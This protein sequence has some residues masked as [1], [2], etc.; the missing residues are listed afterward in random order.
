M[1][2]AHLPDLPF[3]TDAENTE[4][5]RIQETRLT[6]AE[7]DLLV[8]EGIISRNPHIVSGA[9]VFTGTRVPVYNLWDYL[10]SG[11]SLDEFLESFP[12]VSRAIAEKAITL[13]GK[14]FVGGTSHA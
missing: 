1:P 12:T 9:F 11:D 13:V 4:H 6:R 7:L 5:E 8:A 10:S 2:Q 3:S 14:R